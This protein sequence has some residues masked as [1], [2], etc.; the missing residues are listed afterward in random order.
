MKDILLYLSFLLSFYNTCY[1][2]APTCSD[3]DLRAFAEDQ[4][5]EL[6][7]KNEGYGKF[8]PYSTEDAE[9]Y[10]VTLEAGGQSYPVHALKFPASI[11]PSKG[12]IFVLEGGPAEITG[13]G[14]PF[15][16]DYDVVRFDYIG[17]G[18]N[19]NLSATAEMMSLEGQAQA[20]KKIITA[21]KLKNYVIYGHSFGTPVATIT[22]SIIGRDPK[23][24]DYQPRSVILE[25]TVG[26]RAIPPNETRES[27]R[28]W[29]LLTPAEQQIFIQKYETTIKFLTPRLKRNLDMILEMSLAENPRKA[30]DA[31]KHFQVPVWATSPEKMKAMFPWADKPLT[32]DE[33]NTGISRMYRAAGCQVLPV[34]DPPEKLFNGLFSNV[35]D[36]T[37]CRCRSINRDFDSAKFQIKSPVLYIQGDMDGQAT[38]ENARYHYDH[39]TTKNKSMLVVKD[40]GHA[41]TFDEMANCTPLIYAAAFAGN[42]S[43]LPETKDWSRGCGPETNTPLKV[44]PTSK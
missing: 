21:M 15:P 2:D 36:T 19:A 31:L 24:K 41:S 39:Q 16:K 25:G 8:S 26:T 12:T 17:L 30:A 13:R 18:Q 10:T 44:V 27:N 20:A 22:A 7:I 33:V 32:P 1:A 14:G 35:L 40:G 37:V 9:K 11:T 43:N 28:A 6:Q 42:W 23:M 29:D 3:S 5:A 4:K 38:I 34:I